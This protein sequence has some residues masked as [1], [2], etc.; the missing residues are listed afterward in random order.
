MISIKPIPPKQT[1]PV[2][3]TVLPADK[4]FQDTKLLNDTEGYHL[5]LF[6]DDELISVI[7]LFSEEQD[8]EFR[9]FGTVLRKQKK[10]Y[11]S[12]LLS[13]LINYSKASGVKKLWCR[14]LSTTCD[15]YRR[16]GFHEAQEVKDKNGNPFIVMELDL[17]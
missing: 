3:Y 6:E 9:K 8:M 12:Q 17:S 14:A 7:S 2:R 15:F 1:W 16:F 11:G 13:Y 5:G 10:G 4:E